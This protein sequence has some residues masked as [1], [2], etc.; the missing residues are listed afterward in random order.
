M[1][2]PHGSVGSEDGG[3]GGVTVENNLS[4]NPPRNL[5]L[6]S[7]VM[8]REAPEAKLTGGRKLVGQS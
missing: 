7:T 3:G 5:V 6:P 8:W 4:Q 1:S 2:A